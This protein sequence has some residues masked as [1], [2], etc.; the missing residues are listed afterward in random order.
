[1]DG[2]VE[3][4]FFDGKNASLFLVSLRFASQLLRHLSAISFFPRFFFLFVSFFDSRSNELLV[5]SRISIVSGKCLLFEMIFRDRDGSLLLVLVDFAE[6]NIRIML[7]RTKLFF[8]FFFFEFILRR[9]KFLENIYAFYY[10][11]Y[12][13]YSFI[14][15]LYLVKNVCNVKIGY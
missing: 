6:R 12:S 2:N 11:L 7:N 4:R 10:S 1:M 15:L 8:F 9:F 3:S 13:L 14:Y 5:R